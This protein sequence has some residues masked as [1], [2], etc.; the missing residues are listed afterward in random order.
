MEGGVITVSVANSFDH[1]S[2]TFGGAEYIE[3][4]LVTVANSSFD[5]NLANK[6]G[7]AVY[8]NGGSINVANSFFDRNS[9]DGE[10]GVSYMADLISTAIID[11]TTLRGNTANKNGGVIQMYHA[12]IQI[13]DGHAVS[14]QLSNA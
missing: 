6:D 3:G 12:S 13:T 2:A 14:Q 7:C 5:H 1:N 11:A 4:G 10:G 9:A 8:M